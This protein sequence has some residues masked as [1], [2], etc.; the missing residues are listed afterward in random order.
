M[1]AFVQRL[2]LKHFI[3]LHKSIFPRLFCVVHSATP[4]SCGGMSNETV[5]RSTFTKESVHGKIKKIPG[6]KTEKAC[7]IYFQ[8]YY[9]YINLILLLYYMSLS[10][11]SIPTLSSSFLMKTYSA[12]FGHLHIFVFRPYF[13]R[14][15]SWELQFRL[16][17][18]FL[19]I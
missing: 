11:S 16:K 15:E 18:S 19:S 9:F 4:T 10:Q 8:K 5:R 6:D 2:E 7:I 12:K 14:N 13:N 1:C 3:M 17:W